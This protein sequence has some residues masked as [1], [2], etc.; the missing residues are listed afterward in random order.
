MRSGSAL[1]PTSQAAAEDAGPAAYEEF[2][3]ELASTQRDPR[4]ELA[5][6]IGFE[7][8]SKPLTAGQAR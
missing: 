8:C 5:R 6:D 3:A 7:E 2:Q 1:T 4:Y